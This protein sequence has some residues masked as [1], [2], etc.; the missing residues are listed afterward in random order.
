MHRLPFLATCRWKLCL[1]L[2]I[3]FLGDHLFYHNAL[4]GGRLGIFAF[5]LLL[6][7]VL[8]RPNIFRQWEGRLAVIFA[9]MFGCALIIDPG[10]LSWAMFWVAISLAALFG[11]TE[12]FDD[13][14]LWFQRLLLHALR[15]PIAP[16]VDFAK[17]RKAARRVRRSR[18]SL[19]GVMR[20]IGLPLLGSAIILA[21]FATANPII[22]QVLAMIDWPD[23]SAI[24]PLRMLLWSMLFALSWSV[25]RPRIARRLIPTFDG[26]GDLDLPGVSVASVTLSLFLFNALFAIENA[27]DIAYLSRALPLPK[28]MSIAD[29]VH[30]GA[31]PLIVTALLAGLF[32]LITL[33]PSSSTA[34]V[35][36]IRRLVVLWIF[37]NIVLVASSAQRTLEYIDTNML[38]TLRIHALAWMAL[39]ATGLV[40]IC[41]R[42]LRE[43]SASWLINTNLAAA[44]SVLTLF[45]FLDAGAVVAQWNV[46]HA[47]EVTGSGPNV[48]LCYL[49]QLGPSALLP[50]I[51]LES[52]TKDPLFKERVQAIRTSIYDSMARDARQGGWTW[53][54]EQRLAAAAAMLKGTTSVGHDPS[55]RHCDGS[56]EKPQPESHGES[57]P[58]NPALQPFTSSAPLTRR[59]ER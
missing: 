18:V 29:Y 3:V 31:Y 52:Q 4:F 42:M 41:W 23:F 6:C 22:G 33:R 46:R 32:V 5:A 1:G 55:P 37:Q 25:L 53:R 51:A 38:T 30:R 59:S 8:A 15:S 13:G 54:N 21:L 26:S 50:L 7:L 44:A 16:L 57:E 10:L 47:R 24:T 11:A 58:A 2:A 43:K 36:M 39:V 12:Q 19:R 27:L 45:C 14:W 28:G 56:R 34:A 9:G 17:A 40:L 20:V 35:P 49:D 48:D